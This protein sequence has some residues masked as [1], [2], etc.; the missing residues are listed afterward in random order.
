MPVYKHNCL[1]KGSCRILLKVFFMN[2]YDGHHIV[3]NLEE[4]TLDSTEP[5]KL[6]LQKKMPSEFLVHTGGLWK[7]ISLTDKKKA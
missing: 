1:T 7:L 3:D 2:N 5:L 4:N 6:R